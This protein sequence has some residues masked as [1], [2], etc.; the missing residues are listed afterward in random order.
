[1][2]EDSQ[3]LKL[4]EAYYTVANDMKRQALRAIDIASELERVAGKLFKENMRQTSTADRE[5][6]SQ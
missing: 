6:A 5:D 2:T 3:S 1:M 4:A